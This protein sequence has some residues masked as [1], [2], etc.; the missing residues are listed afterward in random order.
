MK[1]PNTFGVWGNTE[2]DSFWNILPDILHWA[3]DNNLEAHLTRR[4]KNSQRC[5]NK[6]R[7]LIQSKDDMSALDFMLV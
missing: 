1:V 5:I 4:I 6:K 3:D 2:K 7:P